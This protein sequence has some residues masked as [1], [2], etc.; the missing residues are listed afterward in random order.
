M[1]AYL[2]CSLPGVMVKGTLA[3]MPAD[4]ACLATLDALAMSSYD[5]FVQ[6][7]IRPAFNSVGHLFSLNASANCR[8]TA[9][10]VA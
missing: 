6:L 7:P 5:E 9:Y 8:Y 1:V 2:I 4:K 10:C 3:L